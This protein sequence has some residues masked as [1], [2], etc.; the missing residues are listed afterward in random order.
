MI[1]NMKRL[2]I[3]VLLFLFLLSSVSVFADNEEL[4]TID[5][6]SLS[7]SLPGNVIPVIRDSESS[8]HSYQNGVIL[9][10]NNLAGQVS[11]SFYLM[12]YCDDDL[13][14]LLISAYPSPLAFV[15][16]DMLF[17]SGICDGL[18]FQELQRADSGFEFTAERSGSLEF[19]RMRYAY[20]SGISDDT[21]TPVLQL[22]CIS[23][24]R[25]ICFTF[26]AQGSSSSEQLINLACETMADIHF[27][28][29]IV[30]SSIVI[31]IELVIILLVIA[32]LI[33]LFMLRKY[34]S[35]EEPDI[36]DSAQPDSEEESVIDSYSKEAFRARIP[37]PSRDT[38]ECSLEHCTH[39]L[40]C[41]TLAEVRAKY[42]QLSFVYGDGN[43]DPRIT[44]EI[45]RQYALLLQ[46][47]LKQ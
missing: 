28:R 29:S 22:V 43:I 36:I 6:L 18:L 15:L 10:T 30:S 14:T 32:L 17:C 12:S 38:D 42:E 39:F 47:F 3:A 41:H 45:D 19:N 26:R 44:R 5:E 46:H 2:F 37:T 11:S 35:A 40:D 1:S 4:Y 34:R 13:D 21:G 25:L 33:M 20:R 31:G 7:L 9:D 23:D 8:V 27:Q 24:A 16:R